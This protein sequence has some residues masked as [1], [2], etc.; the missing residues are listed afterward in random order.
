MTPRG[1]CIAAILLA[2]S[3]AA[4]IGFA[5][6]LVGA[7]PMSLEAAIRAVLAP[8]QGVDGIIVWTLRMPRS[9]AAFLAGAAL[10]VAGLLLQIITRNPLAAPDLTGV[11][12]GAVLLIVFTFVAF[13]AISSVFYPFIGMSGGL[14]AVALTIWAARSGRGPALHLALSG[15]TVSLFLN[16]LTAYI[17]IRGAPQSPSMLFWL[18]GGFQGRSWPQVSY[19]LPWVA[20][21]IGAALACH[22]V[23]GLLSLGDEAAAG[24][25]LNAARW[26]LVLLLC[27]AGLVAGVTPIAGPIAFIGLTVPHLVRLRSFGDTA[28]CVDRR[29]SAADSRR[30]RTF[31]RGAEGDPGQHLHRADR[32][33][34]LSLSR[35]APPVFARQGNGVMSLATP[36]S[37]RRKG[38]LILPLTI[39]ALL[40][41]ASVFL[42][43]VD[44]PA[45]DILAVLIGGGSDDA[46]LII[47]TIRIPRIVTGMLAGAHFAVAGLLLQ[48]ITRNPLADPTILGISQ[49]ATLTVAIFLL[50]TVYG[51]SADAHTLY[52]LPLRWLP[53]VACVGGMAT[54]FLVFW[55]AIRN[56]LS[57]LRLTLSGIAIGATLHAL[58]MGMIAGWGSARFE[59]VMQW[60]S[61]SLYARSWEHVIFLLPFTVA[62]VIA[63]PLLHR[64]LDMLRFEEDVARSF[65]LSYR[66]PDLLRNRIPPFI[67]VRIF[68]VDVEDDA[69]EREHPMA[70]HLSDLKFGVSLFH[71]AT[72][73]FRQLSGLS[74]MEHQ[75][76]SAPVSELPSALTEKGGPRMK[77][78][79]VVH[80]AWAEPSAGLPVPYQT[81]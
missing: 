7:K 72:H 50:F 5:A 61:G 73:P 4:L 18:S 26:K 81:E 80:L 2:V 27:A 33:A 44:L 20:I 30:A 21:G 37:A 48:A 67:G 13:P 9:I 60:L 63:L 36:R 74:H 12:A 34:G 46:D 42:G 11:S 57:L 41:I 24:M 66:L 59:I 45:K 69:A 77:P 25:G 68:R 62:A 31:R 54:G 32:R 49:G 38:V 22:R 47:G 3:T 75:E 8:N 16:A 71:D 14:L 28:E 15:I 64:S 79:S 51:A 43:V 6:L 70:N 58:A 1:R 76:G 56:H 23:I 65:G 17:L 52:R 55:I 19:M 29:R 40:L 78:A 35:A 53:L 39:S 10:A